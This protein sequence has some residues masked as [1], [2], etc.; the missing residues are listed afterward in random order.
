[1]TVATR[2][3]VGSTRGEVQICRVEEV[4]LG[5]GRAFRIEGLDIAIFRSRSGAVHAVDNRCPHR[6]G[7]LADGMLAG[8]RVVCPFHAF[9]YDLDTGA[10]DQLD[11]CA[12]RTFPTRVHDGWV[13]L[14][15]TVTDTAR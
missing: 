9:R 6:G 14:Q 10:C 15:T 11:S 2:N 3:D 1:V 5:L 7:P 4:P 8:N 12:A 13:L